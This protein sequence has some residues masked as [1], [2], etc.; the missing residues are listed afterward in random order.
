MDPGAKVEYAMKLD[1]GTGISEGKDGVVESN[2]LANYVH[3]HAA[4]YRGFPAQFL[5]VCR[6]ER[7]K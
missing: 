4:S 7:A 1:R 5:A 3:L 6:G 2:M